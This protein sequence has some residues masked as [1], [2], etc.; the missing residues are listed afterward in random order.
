M[1]EGEL[2]AACS[3]VMEGFGSRLAVNTEI[4]ERLE[5]HIE[6]T[7]GALLEHVKVAGT[8]FTEIEARQLRQDGAF[9]AFKWLGGALVGAMSLGIAL[10]G[11]ALV[12]VARGG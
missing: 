6:K 3:G 4:L 2:L 10:A 11:V 5:E 1:T 12:V 8:R 9:G 7:N